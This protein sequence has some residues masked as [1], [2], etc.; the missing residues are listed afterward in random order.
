MPATV[1][2][3]HLIKSFLSDKA[4]LSRVLPFATFMCFVGLDEVGR[5]ATEKG[6]MALSPSTLYYLYPLRVAVVALLLWL[7]RD[8]YRELRLRDLAAPAR[9]AAVGAVGLATCVMWVLMDWSVKAPGHGFDPTLLPPGGI[10]TAL[11]AARVAGAVL[12]VPLMEELFWRSFLLR[13][14]VDPRFESV[15]PG[16]FTWGSFLA[17]TIL[18]GLEHDLL[19]AGMVAGAVYNAVLYQT[20]SLSHCVLAHAVTNLVLAC[21]V[22]YTGRWYF[23]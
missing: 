15:E 3:N 5:Y 2:K 23:W 18:F 20:R 10:R 4:V 12:V 7:F 8:H 19:V 1:I 9:T 14:L 21:Y 13:Y 16:R 11:T 17:T 6:L 22:L